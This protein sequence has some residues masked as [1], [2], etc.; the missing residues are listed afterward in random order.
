MRDRVRFNNTAYQVV[1]TIIQP[2]SE[3]NF[4]ADF[5]Q[6]KAGGHTQQKWWLVFWRDLIRR[7]ICVDAPIGA[8]RTRFSLSRKLSWKFVPRGMSYCH[9]YITVVI[10]GA[11]RCPDHRKHG[12]VTGFRLQQEGRGWSHRGAVGVKYRYTNQPR[13]S[14]KHPPVGLRLVLCDARKAVGAFGVHVCR[15]SNI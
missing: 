6:P 2:L 3:T 7:H 8:V 10:P 13:V 5:L 12:Q 11:R 9:T 4:T 1:L 14:L 15:S